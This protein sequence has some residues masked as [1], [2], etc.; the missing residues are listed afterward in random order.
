MEMNTEKD[1]EF[2]RLKLAAAN[3]ALNTFQ[4]IMSDISDYLDSSDNQL[5]DNELEKINRH[6][7]NLTP[8]VDQFRHRV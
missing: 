6:L 4:N 2:L 7:N 8:W 1:K 3:N 5:F